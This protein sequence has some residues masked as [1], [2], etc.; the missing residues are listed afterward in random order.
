MIMPIMTLP[1]IRS[2]F[3]EGRYKITFH[4]RQQ[5]LDREIYREDLAYVFDQGEIIREAPNARPNPKVQV[6]ALLPNNRTLIVVVSKPRSSQIIRIVT[7]FYNDEEE[8]F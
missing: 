6:A 8:E 2:A 1:E 5:M 3:E 7:V 4:A